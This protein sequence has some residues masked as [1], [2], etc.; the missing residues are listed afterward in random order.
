ML[1]ETHAKEN[2]IA[3]HPGHTC[4]VGTMKPRAVGLVTYIMK[5]I[6]QVDVSDRNTENVE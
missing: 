3:A 6:K 2:D 4:Y 5:E 1:Q